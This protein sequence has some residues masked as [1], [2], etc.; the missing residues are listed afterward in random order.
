[1]TTTQHFLFVMAPCICRICHTPSVQFSVSRVA[2]FADL[3]SDTFTY[4]V[5]KKD[6]E[7]VN[8]PIFNKSQLNWFENQQVDNNQLSL[9]TAQPGPSNTRLVEEGEKTIVRH[10]SEISCCTQS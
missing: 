7:N 1:M 3:P 4:K 9:L 2:S 8:T 5:R 6:I 10:E